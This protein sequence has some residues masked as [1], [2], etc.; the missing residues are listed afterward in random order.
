MEIQEVAID[1]LIKK[2]LKL[3]GELCH[4]IHMY[5]IIVAIDALIKKGLKPQRCQQVWPGHHET[6]QVAIDALIKKGLKLLYSPAPGPVLRQVA[7]D[8]LI[9]KGLKLLCRFPSP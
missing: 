4:D 9:K 3:P 1:A 6:D 7:I 2:G 8:A 5:I